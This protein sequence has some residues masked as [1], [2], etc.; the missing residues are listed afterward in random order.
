MW[1]SDLH[2]GSTI[3]LSPRKFRLPEG[4]LFKPSKSQQIINRFWDGFWE[5]RWKANVQTVVCFGGDLVDSYHHR[6]LQVWTTDETSMIDAAVELLSP[7][8][9]KS[10][11]CFWVG[12]TPAHS[13][14]MSRWDRTIMRELGVTSLTDSDVEFRNRIVISGVVVDVAHHGPRVSPKVWLKENS[15]RSY[16]K[17]VMLDCLSRHRLPPDIIVRG[18]VHVQDRQEVSL[19]EYTTRIAISPSWQ[20]KSEFV[21]RINSE[22]DLADV[23]GVV[24]ILENGKVHSLDFDSIELDGTRDIV[25]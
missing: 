14:Q 7:I 10:K 18:H 25:L 8:V 11:K 16:A 4:N 12:G 5:R 9:T 21:Y 19:G 20:W 2:I 17:N 13:G 24:A 22:T 15:V 3:A 6:T 1:V 23:G